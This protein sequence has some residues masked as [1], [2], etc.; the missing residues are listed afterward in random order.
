VET[1]RLSFGPGDVLAFMPEDIHSIVNASS[2]L[3]LSLNLYG[4]SYAA[5]QSEKFDPRAQTVKPLL[6][7]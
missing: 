6:A 7:P 3:A 4:V 1:G 2:Q 5:T